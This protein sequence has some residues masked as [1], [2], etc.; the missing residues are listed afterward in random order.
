MDTTFNPPA[1]DTP[2]PVSRL[3]RLAREAIERT[4]PLCWISGE[5]SN[6]TRAASG[7]LY[8]TLKD[9]QAQ[10][11]CTMWRSRAQLLPYRIDNGQRVEIRALPT[12]YE[13][14]GEFQLNV[15][16]VRQAG[17]GSLYEAFLR[18]RDQLAREG[19][20]DA[21]RKRPLPIYPTGIGI[22][23]S[24]QAAALRDV[25]AALARRAAAVP[26]FIYPAAVQGEAAAGALRAAI[27]AAGA[28]AVVDGVDVLLLV[29]G[30]GSIE[31]LWAF[32]DADLARAIRAS[33]I[34][35]VSGVGHETDFTIAD[36]AADLRA[37]TPTAAAEIVSA[38]MA[39]LGP[40][41]DGAA[42]ALRSAMSRRLDQ[43]AQRLDRAQMRLIHPARRIEL[44]RE[45]L[46]TLAHRLRAAHDRCHVSRRN[47]LESLAVRLTALCPQPALARAGL[48]QW[49]HRLDQALL[50]RHETARQ[51]ID[52]MENALALLDP[53]AV[54]TRGYS[55]TRD[56]SGHI[57]KR[58][59]ELE[60]G[61]RIVVELSQGSL[62][63]VVTELVGV[64]STRDLSLPFNPD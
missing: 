10:V 57:V 45:R 33:P 18:L 31:D 19:L 37:A 54:L 38:G 50:R 5:V 16:A 26:L 9:E 51:R 34:P 39:A 44:L 11:R 43:A 2:I 59:D 32:N 55:I 35:V 46:D 40:W 15:E 56:A 21:A 12:L 14:R 64:P 47:R 53:R 61:A 29:R 17:Q 6:L 20:F 3:N 24:L 30:G 4:L 8:F 7:H 23:T 58:A 62:G 52:A 13:A 28:R 60:T 49:A 1:A 36:F 42:R 22:V 48:A 63:G 27:A 41:V 25:L